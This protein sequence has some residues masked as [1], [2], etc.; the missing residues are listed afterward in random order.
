MSNAPV[1]RLTVSEAAERSGL[2]IDTL[3][4]Y[5]RI[6]LIDP[7]P[8]SASGQRLY[9]EPELER[10]ELVNR[11]RGTGMSIQ[12]MLDYAELVRSGPETMERRRA[13]LAEH[14]MRL[15][16]EMDRLASTVGYLDR[17][18]GVYDAHLGGAA[19]SADP[20]APPSAPPGRGAGEA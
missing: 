10:L 17:K 3:R 8:R 6:G 14:R 11:L 15:C 4:Y 7:V 13:M 9:G 5:E 16:A 20:A 1:R 19:A 18:I 2:T 12:E